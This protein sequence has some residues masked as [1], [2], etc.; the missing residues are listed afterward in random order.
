MRHSFVISAIALIVGLVACVS[1]TVPLA[2]SE[3]SG[4]DGGRTL[5]LAMPRTEPTPLEA[6][7]LPASVHPPYAHRQCDTCHRSE[8]GQEAYRPS[9]G[10]CLRCHGERLQR[11]QWD[12]GPLNFGHC[13][14]C[15]V[16]HYSQLPHLE[17]QPQPEL[18]TRCHSAEDLM[19]SLPLHR[20]VES[21]R[22][23]DCHDPHRG[24]LRQGAAI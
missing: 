24:G 23:T 14:I 15:H 4:E 17:N 16:P 1:E 3:N 7:D 13:L 21:Q 6:P 12:H 2:T 20:G 22:C 9:E 11:E 10:L 18:C 5:I 19:S 8:Q